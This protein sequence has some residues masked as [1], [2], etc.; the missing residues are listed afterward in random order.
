MQEIQ[1]LLVAVAFVLVVLLIAFRSEVRKM[2]NWELT[3]VKKNES[4]IA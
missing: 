2:V 4:K 3:V 1:P